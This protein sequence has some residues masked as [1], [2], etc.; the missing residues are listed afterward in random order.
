MLASS[1]ATSAKLLTLF[2]NQMSCTRLTNVG[3][4]QV[5]TL[6][7]RTRRTLDVPK[8]KLNVMPKITQQKAS[9]SL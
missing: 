9:E 5:E 7:N 8:S 2:L 3:D 1:E 6:R 4:I